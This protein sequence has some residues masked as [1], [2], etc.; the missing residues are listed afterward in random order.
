MA[1]AM[2]EAA[3]KLHDHG[4]VLYATGGTSRYLTDNGI[5]NTLV[6]W[7]SQEQMQPQALDLLH[8]HEIDMVV[9]IPKDLTQGELRNG[10][11]LRRAAVDL[12]IPLITNARLA[13]AFIN[14]FTTLSLDD[15]AIRSWNEYK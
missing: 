4:Y 11:R 5:P 8:Q 1:A 9:N 6:Y 12:N 3:R 14:A 7:P 13:S 2:L 10:Y 15:L